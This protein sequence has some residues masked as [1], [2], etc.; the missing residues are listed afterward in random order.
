MSLE[1]TNQSG[2]E[3]FRFQDVKQGDTFSISFTPNGEEPK[4][5]TFTIPEGTKGNITINFN[6]ELRKE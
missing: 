2:N 5:F 3:S 4:T 1:P 6:K